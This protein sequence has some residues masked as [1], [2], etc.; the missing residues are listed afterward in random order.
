M[1]INSTNYK[2]NE[3]NYITEPGNYLF[4]LIKWEQDGF[5]QNGEE[6]IKVTCEGMKIK[7]DGKLEG[8]Y[9]FNYQM[10]NG[11]KAGFTIAMLRDALK[12]PAI[13]NLDDWLNRY[14][15]AVVA[16]EAGNDGKM[17]ARAKKFEYSKANDKLSP[18]PS[19]EQGNSE[20]AS[21]SVQ[22]P[23]ED[24]TEDEIPF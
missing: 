12:S 15:I 1:Q 2:S 11:E 10:Y 14:V 3:M 20:P 24:I 8:N 22:N 9:S 19:I 5:S 16:M 13:F 6:K 17:Y 23:S 21:Q 4:K 18:I 7:E